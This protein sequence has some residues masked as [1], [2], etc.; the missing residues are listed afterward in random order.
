VGVVLAS[1]GATMAVLTALV[2]F[3]THRRKRSAG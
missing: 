2:L 1:L 3:A